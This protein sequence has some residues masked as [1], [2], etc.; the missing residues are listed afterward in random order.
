MEDQGIFHSS[1]FGFDKQEVL[2]YVDGM[3][4]KSK[5]TET[6][7]KKQADDMKTELDAAKT[8][9][10]SSRAKLKELEESAAKTTEDSSVHSK[11]IEE[12]D[13]R[14]RELEQRRAAACAENETLKKKMDDMGEKSRKYD[15]ATSQIGSVMFEAQKQGEAIVERA[16]KRA[17]EVAQSSV[18]SIYEINKRLDVFKSD[19][20]RLRT[21]TQDILKS[22]DDKMGDID[23]ALKRAEGC[24]YINAGK[25]EDGTQSE[26]EL[27]SAPDEAQP[28]RDAAAVGV[29]GANFF[30]VPSQS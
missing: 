2:K 20:Q 12:R 3:I 15:E 9:L 27:V 19:I 6:K 5:E 10:E 16:Q 28:L 22:F 8:E 26:E 17:E 23:M 29:I 18:E 25:S 4:E 14:I 11:T 7:L 30:G 1:M 21:I 24:L 13:A